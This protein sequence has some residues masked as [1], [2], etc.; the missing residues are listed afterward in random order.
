MPDQLMQLPPVP[1]LTLCFVMLMC[2][3]PWFLIYIM[4]EILFKGA[5][6]VL[7]Y[8]YYVHSDIYD[9]EVA[10][11]ERFVYHLTNPTW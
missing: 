7:G 1:R 11:D 6:Y 5:R 3:L 10:I 9:I 8:A 2:L 4:A